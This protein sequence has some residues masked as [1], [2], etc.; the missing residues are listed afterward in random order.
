MAHNQAIAGARP[1]FSIVSESASCRWA[2][3]G[4]PQASRN[5]PIAGRAILGPT[6]ASIPF[7]GG[8][9][10]PVHTLRIG[11][12][13]SNTRPAAG[14]EALRQPGVLRYSCTSIQRRRHVA[15]AR[16]FTTQATNSCC[17]LPGGCTRAPDHDLGERRADHGTGSLRRPG[18]FSIPFGSTGLGARYL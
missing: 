5:I 16:G 14:W 11:G 9:V 2:F 6:R 3:E 4:T 18:A 10:D 15:V 8:R 17:W 7:P 12:R 1:D 13:V